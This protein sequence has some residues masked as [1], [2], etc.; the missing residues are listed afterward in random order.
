MPAQTLRRLLGVVLA[1]VA[2]APLLGAG[3]SPR[4]PERSVEAGV[5]N[6]IKEDGADPYLFFHDGFYYLTYTRND[7]I[8]LSK[9]RSVTELGTAPETTIWQDP[10]PSRCC[11]MWA[12]EVHFLDG[13]FYVYYTATNEG[14]GHVPNHRMY[15]LESAGADPLG[16]YTFKGPL[17]AAADHYSIDG[18]VM[19][20]PDG[21]LYAIWS[22][23]DP[24]TTG[25][26]NLY[27]AP[28]SNPWTTSGPR[29]KLSSPTYDWEK[30]HAPVN[31]G[32]VPL[33]RD[34]QLFLVYSA[35][36]CSSPNYALGLLTFR[37]GS[38]L[39]PAAWSKSPTPVFSSSSSAGVYTTGHNSVF[40][41]PDG[42]E[43]WMAYHGVANPGGSCG[44]DRATRIGK[45]TWRADGTPSFGT[46]ASTGTTLRLPSGDPGSLSVP[47]G[48]YELMAQHSGKVLAARGTSVVT[49]TS[50]GS[51]AQRWRVRRLADG[52]Y[53][54]QSVGSGK[55]L[56]VGGCAV[57]DGAPVVTAASDRSA[58]QRWYVDAAYGAYSRVTSVLSGR[59]LD[60]A[61]SSPEDGAA[62]VVWPYAY[63]PNE[64]WLLRRVS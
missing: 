47:L 1:V 62:V 43:T 63:A 33:W 42:S 55:V 32:A 56:A 17:A 30:D 13:R 57:A 39:D 45:I 61:W 48:D 36:G 2:L 44:G 11:G 10:T 5:R 22:G 60:V 9:A 31:E 16:P 41:S 8:A 59:G 6:P 24:G 12:P 38:V 46:P 7:R 29:V 18:T 14:D 51:R 4:P 50:T 34:G 23:W 58:C 53:T 19:P 64:R 15:V 54:L 28:M 27:I 52:S 25:P 37:G 35:S 20:M 3:P 40:T 26:Q 49:E 21:S